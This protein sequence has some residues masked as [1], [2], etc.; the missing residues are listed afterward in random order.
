MDQQS[1][2]QLV[3]TLVA[4]PLTLFFFQRFINKADQAKQEEE[5]GWREN[6]KGMFSRLENKVSTYCTDN[7]KDHD[8][9][10]GSTNDLTTRVSVIENTHHQRGCDQPFRRSGE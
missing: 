6:V 10:Y 1:L 3:I 5:Y 9:L 4:I 8:D 7:H 2:I